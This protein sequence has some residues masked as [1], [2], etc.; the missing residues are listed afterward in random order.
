[1]TILAENPNI[2]ALDK[3]KLLSLVKELMKPIRYVFF[4]GEYEISAR[5]DG[6]G[7]LVKTW[8]RVR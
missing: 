2:D 4:D 3:A 7:N 1:M 8:A 6:D 5:L